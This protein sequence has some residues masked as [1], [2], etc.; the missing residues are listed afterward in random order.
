MKELKILSFF[1]LIFAVM[2]F[3]PLENASIS[4]AILEAFKLLQ[5]YVR[6][7]TLSCVI[8]ALFISGAIITF[9]SQASVMK[10]LGPQAKKI[11]AYSVASVSGAILAV[12]S[13][14]VLPMF[15]GIYKMGAGLGPASAFLYSG[16]AINV[17]AIFL[18]A[19]VLGFDIGLARAFGAIIFACLLGVI[20]A[21]IFRKSEEEKTTVALQMPE[22][23]NP[24]SFWKTT[25]FMFTMVLFLIIANWSNTSNV[26]VHSN[27][28]GEMQ[29]I[30][31]QKTSEK[32]VVQLEQDIGSYKT[33]EKIT[34]DPKDISE[35]GIVVEKNLMSSIHQ[36][37]WYVSGLLG[38]IVIIMSWKWF[39][40]DEIKTW[41]SNTWDFTKIL[42]PILFIGV[43]IVGF[44]AALLPEKQIAAL[45]GDNS[46]KSNLVASIIGA[47]FYFAT[48]TEV[49]ILQSLIKLGMHKGPALT[50]LLAGPALSLPSMIAIWKIMGGKKA[51]VFIMLIIIISAC[52]GML[53]GWIA[54]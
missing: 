29:C 21:T 35:K 44:V 39:S 49:P 27:Q 47:F 18:T 11:Y 36:N 15:A 6:E 41:F 9:L 50:L 14:T 33:G 53:F 28:F 45:V 52:T 26:T 37:R 54:G 46:L 38:I 12:C 7:H 8:P 1:V 13:C 20:M 23:E 40:R 34:L 3:I 32:V 2:Y 17:M 16:P 31:L 4:N 19:R 51:F 30:L 22:E 24:R 43:F 48:L 42:I 10:Y 5:W 25:S